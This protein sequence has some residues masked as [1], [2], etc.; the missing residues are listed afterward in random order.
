MD[1]ELL[2]KNAKQ[3][4]DAIKNLST[5]KKN[6]LLQAIANKLEAHHDFILEKNAVDVQKAKEQNLSEA[7]V[8]RLTLNEKRFKEIIDGI[9]KVITLTDPVNEIIEG[10]EVES[11]LSIVK[12]RV[13][14]GVVAVIYESRPNVTVDI[15]T[16]CI[17]SGNCCI[18]K[19]GKEAS[20]T[21]LILFNLMQEVLLELELNKNIISLVNSTDR[22]DVYALLKQDQYIDVIIPR[23][24]FKLQR[25][26]LENSTI[27]VITGGFGISHIFADESC[28]LEKSAQVIINAK[29]QKPSACNA[30]DTLILHEKVAKDL[31]E[32]LK[33]SFLQHH[34]TV[35]ACP[36]SFAYFS[37]YPY[38][39]A[40]QEG[41]LDT[42]WLSLHC[43]CIVVKDLNEACQILKD[44]NAS[45]SDA[46]LTNNLANANTFVNKAPSACVYVNASTRFTDGGQFGFGSEVAISTQKLHVRGPMGL[47]E[48]TTY[49]YVLSGDYLVRS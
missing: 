6:E 47:K 32:L 20:E 19:G 39:K 42:E 17:K 31:I 36:Q 24:G 13:P 9:K 45:H 1:I 28:S 49:Q 40:L 37:D 11:S 3:A 38:V 8:D 5:Q 30:L 25:L 14:F 22:Q 43:S 2:C 27:P 26:C 48:L 44:H 23:G 18:L 33:P 10:Y 21:N 4:S 34:V 15:A 41:D 12:K 29:V 16:L 35:H 46:I 7:L